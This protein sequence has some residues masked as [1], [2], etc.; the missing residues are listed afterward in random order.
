MDLNYTIDFVDGFKIIG[1]YKYILLIVKNLASTNIE[2]WKY[3]GAA[4]GKIL[5]IA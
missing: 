4:N 3:G 2:I 5:L 1:E